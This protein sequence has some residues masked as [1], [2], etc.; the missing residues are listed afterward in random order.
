VSVLL[1]CCGKTFT[2]GIHGTKWPINVTVTKTFT[3]GN[4]GPKRPRKNV[5]CP[6]KS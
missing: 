4:L 3:L 1:D 2:S 5:R 6:W